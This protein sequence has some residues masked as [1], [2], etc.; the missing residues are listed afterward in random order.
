MENKAKKNMDYSASAVNL[1]NP[2]VVGAALDVLHGY[3][4]DLNI[5]EQDIVNAV[6]PELLQ[7]KNEIQKFIEGQNQVIRGMVDSFGSFQDLESGYYAVKQR[8]MTRSY[9]AE[10]FELYFP[11]FAPAIL[12]KSVNVPALQG[13]IKG[14]LLTEESILPIIKETETFAYIIK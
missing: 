9:D 3:Q 7:K 10:K 2:L 12:T 1:I 5:V 4:T 14:K 8:R 13:L 11:N 6:P